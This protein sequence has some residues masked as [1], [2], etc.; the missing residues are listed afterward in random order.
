MSSKY[1]AVIF[2]LDGLLVDTEKIAYQLYVDLLREYGYSISR[3][4]YAKEH[5][6]KPALI[7]I[8]DI[9]KEFNL[10]LDV[11]ETRDSILAKENKMIHDGVELKKGAIEL[12]EYLKQ[13]NYKIALATSSLL[14]RAMVML[15]QHHLENY[16]D[17]MVTFG[18]ISKAKP[19]PETFVKAVE[20]LKVNKEEALVL[21]DSDAG[22]M[23]A[24]NGGIPCCLIPDN[25]I[26]SEDIKEHATIVLNDLTEVIDYLKEKE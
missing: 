1:K 17:E 24:Y 26:P 5:G 18:E 12:L 3:E 15:K 16:F 25:K 7:N 11:M 10:P 21:E 6:G 4:K 22:I 8:I 13:N 14:E 2:D 9:I 23:A 20:K 19:D